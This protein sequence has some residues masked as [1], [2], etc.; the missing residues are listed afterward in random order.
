MS[1]KALTMCMFFHM[2]NT[3]VDIRKESVDLICEHAN[4]IVK[5]SEENNINYNIVISMIWNESR[6]Q[7]D[8]VSNKKA[9]GLMQIIPKWSL[10]NYSCD[11]LKNPKDNIKEGIKL[12]VKWR[13]EYGKGSLEKGLCG[14]AAGYNCTDN[15]KNAGQKY[16]K[17]IIRLS[18]RFEKQINTLMEKIKFTATLNQVFINKYKFY[19]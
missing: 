3:D 1:L 9:C 17:K 12:L 7:P 19:L 10:S 4:Q 15:P 14:Y 2:Q 6:F 11:Q 13:D 8:K 18:K 16:S 5:Y